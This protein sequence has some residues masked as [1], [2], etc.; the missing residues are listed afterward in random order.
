[1]GFGPVQR[2]LSQSPSPP[3]K[4]YLFFVTSEGS[5]Q[6]ALIRF[7][8]KGSLV[9]HRTALKLVPGDPASQPD[10]HVAGDGKIHLLSSAHGFPDSDLVT[11]PRD[12]AVAPD[13]RA[14]YVS[15]THGFAGGELLKVRIAADSS[16]RESQPP[17]TVE[18]REPLAA[19]PGA[20]QVSPDGG[21]AWV[22]N[23]AGRDGALTGWVT[24]VYLGSMVEVARIQTCR[25][26]VGSRLTANGSM[27]YSACRQD[28][29]LVEIDAQAMKISRQLPLSGPDQR[30]CEPTA[31]TLAP[32]GSHL[33][34]ACE[35]SGEIL[36]IDVAS[37]S[38]GRRIPV[39]GRPGAVG[40]TR[41]DRT[42]VV[43]DRQRQEVTLFDVRSGDVRA[44]IASPMAGG[45]VAA[46]LALGTDSWP[47][48]TALG[49]RPG[50]RVP[51][52]VAMS[53]DDRYAFVAISRL[54][55]LPGAV[56]VIDLAALKLVATIDVGPQAG[57]IAFWKME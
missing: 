53:P 57:G 6:V 9:E 1:L 48:I 41:D 50:T 36:E 15:T 45:P 46:L 18:G 17:D 44:R 26:P 38:I 25:E 29:M 55:L 23:A 27:H 4:S 19:L 52:S 31:L 51:M 2:A 34:V 12:V 43:T 11:G 39:G 14:Y 42:L 28:D 32:S 5:D 3:A 37:W 22:T 7:G 8:P 24:V 16:H 10:V 20:I 54:G 21:Y 30:R 56:E 35:N 49:M 13:G 33:Y 40:V 47:L